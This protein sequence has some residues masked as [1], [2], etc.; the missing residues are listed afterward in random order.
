M[1]EHL[2]VVKDVEVQVRTGDRDKMTSQGYMRPRPVKL[3]SHHL[4]GPTRPIRTFCPTR[5]KT[6]ESR[7]LDRKPAWIMGFVG[8][9]R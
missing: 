3:D 8:W 1:Q 6:G 7:W 2:G 4:P 9:G 5:K